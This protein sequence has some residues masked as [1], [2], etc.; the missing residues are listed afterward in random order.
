MVIFN[1]ESSESSSMIANCSLVVYLFEEIVSKLA[2]IGSILF[3]CDRILL[4][5]ISMFS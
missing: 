2:F 5:S 4:R 1:L 3:A